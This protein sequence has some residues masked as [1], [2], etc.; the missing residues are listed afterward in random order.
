MA[1]D[2]LVDS[3][4]LDADLTSVADAIREKGGTSAQL[5][6]PDGFVD[7][8][9]AIPSG[10]GGVDYLEKALTNT[11]TSYENE[12]ITTIP[13]IYALAYRSNLESVKLPNLQ[14]LQAH[15]FDGTKISVL[16]LPKLSKFLGWQPFYGMTYLTTLDI[17]GA[18]SAQGQA[19]NGSTALKTLIVRR[20]SDI[21]ALGN[22]N[23]F[24]NTPF[25]SGKAGG[26]LYVPSA[27][28]SSYQSATN[29]STILGYPNNSI[30]AI[31][32]SQYENYYA[33][34]T[35]IT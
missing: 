25:A 13:I 10:G 27:L 16:V 5:E 26:T 21:M 3:T 8:V 34:G 12:N 32:G 22:I 1:V 14:S 35:P 4:Q 11:L 17:L 28:I 2:K 30:Q 33:D 24:N 15:P 9:E 18:A 31:E 6:F 29:W 20:T 23:A 7:A 19:F